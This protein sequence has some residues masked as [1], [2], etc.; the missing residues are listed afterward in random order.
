[1]EDLSENFQMGMSNLKIELFSILI[2]SSDGVALQGEDLWF[3]HL[4]FATPPGEQAKKT[5]SCCIPA[6]LA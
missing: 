5:D 1:M 4:H 6:S 2:F 3:L